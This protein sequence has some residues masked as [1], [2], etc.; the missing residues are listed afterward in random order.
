MPENPNPQGKGLVTLLEQW[1]SVRPAIAEPKNPRT[2]LNDYVVSLL[3]LS[4]Q[5]KFKPV[6]GND[7]HLYR[8]AG[9]WRLSLI[10]PW[11]WTHTQPDAYVGSCI[12]R[13]DMTW[14]L[15]TAA[16]LE[17]QPGVLEDLAEF[18]RNFSDS[19]AKQDSL[20]A[21]LPFYV[22]QLPFYQRLLATG[23]ASSI[24]KTAEISGLAG[25]DAEFWLNGP[26]EDRRAMI[27]Y[28]R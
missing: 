6:V 7:Y 24:S 9:T 16:D 1:E 2:L 23:L 17:C 20:E 18:V 25:R 3:V 22:P 13:T 28:R 10:A 26:V 19:L 27:E 21:G 11:E 5:F 12:L 4:A 15:S 8:S 14:S